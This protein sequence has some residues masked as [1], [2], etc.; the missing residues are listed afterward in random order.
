MW[1]WIAPLAGGILGGIV[2]HSWIGGDS[3][4]T[5]LIGAGVGAIAGGMIKGWIAPREA[6]PAIQATSGVTPP[7]VGKGQQ[8]GIDSL[9]ADQLD[10]LNAER[11]KTA[12][13]GFDAP[14][15]QNPP[16]A[17]HTAQNGRPR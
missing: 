15:N 10:K 4:I 7:Q 9:S 12:Q 13:A 17:Q 14:T 2:T 16:P 8:L 5:T 1:D 6:P 3:I 11:A